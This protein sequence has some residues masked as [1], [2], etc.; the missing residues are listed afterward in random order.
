MFRRYRRR[1]TS[2]L[3]AAGVRGALFSRTPPP[4]HYPADV[5]STPTPDALD[6]PA[7]ALEALDPQR[8]MDHPARTGLIGAGIALG[9]TFQPNLLTRGTTDQAV[10]SGVTTAFAY[11]LYSSADAIVDSLA[12]RISGQDNPGPNSRLIVAG[13][14]AALGAGTFAGFKWR[15]TS[16]ARAQRS[17]SRGDP[18]LLEQSRARRPR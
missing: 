2:T 5:T 7:V 12:A 9:R 1:R 15:S 17:D 3:V 10:I 6:L 8:G 13:V 11:G 4:R 16:R 18:S 14:L